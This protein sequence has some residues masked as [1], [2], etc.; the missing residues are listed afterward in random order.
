MRNKKG[1]SAVIVSMMLVLLAIVSVG[2]VFVVVNN[3]VGDA[4]N[5]VESRQ[6]CLGLS[7]VPINANCDKHANNTGYCDVSYQRKAGGVKADVKGVR[8]TLTD[9]N[10]VYSTE[11]VTNKP[12]EQLQRQTERVV[13]SNSN[14]VYANGTARVKKLEVVPYLE[15]GSDKL[16]VYCPA[17]S[18]SKIAINQ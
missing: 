14:L 13:L 3:A 11:L 2:V 12:L 1:L 9:A 17:T 15:V 18:I 10:E 16:K 5:E 4:Q 8:I 6:G 7:V